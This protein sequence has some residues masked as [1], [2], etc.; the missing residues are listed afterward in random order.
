MR[1][2]IERKYTMDPKLLSLLSDAIRE[3]TLI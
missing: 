3:E 1:F 2:A